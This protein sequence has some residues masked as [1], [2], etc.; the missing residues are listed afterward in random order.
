MSYREKFIRNNK[1]IAREEVPKRGVKSIMSPT[2]LVVQA[3]EQMI[4][5]ERT[6]Q[7]P[8]MYAVH[9][10]NLKTRI[11]H[12]LTLEMDLKKKD[13]IPRITNRFTPMNIKP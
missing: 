10:R 13:P 7:K 1:A 5:Y 2:Q 9:H 3:T 6:C 12:H 8:K 4:L 11:P